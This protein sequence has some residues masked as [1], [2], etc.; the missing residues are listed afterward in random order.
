[1]GGST[2]M[3]YVEIQSAITPTPIYWKITSPVYLCAPADSI[4]IKKWDYF[5][6]L[7]RA[8][9]QR[10]KENQRKTKHF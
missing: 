5:A 9:L 3:F 10:N 6:D 7:S 2:T 8:S 4:F 1:M